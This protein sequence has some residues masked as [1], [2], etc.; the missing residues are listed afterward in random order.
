[1]SINLSVD[2]GKTSVL[3]GTSDPYIIVVSNTGP[4]A[5]TGA[6]VSD[7]LPAGATAATWTSTISGGASVTG[8]ASGSGALATTVNLPASAS[9]TFTFA[10]TINPSATGSFVNAATVTPP[11]GIPF[12]TAD[13]DTLTPTADLSVTITDGR[14]TVVPGASDTYTIV[15]SNAGPSTAVAGTVT[16]LFPAAFT[17]VSWTAVASAGSSVAAATGIGNI[18]TAV[19]L[20]PF[21]TATYTVV[22]L[23][24]PSAAGS[25]PTPRTLSHSVSRHHSS[26]F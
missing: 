7:A 17:S 23:V 6:F 20:L 21:G 2:D 3:P 10:T 25:R 4:S 19:T 1:M 15:V 18:N 26:R 11:G 22:A 8:P 9:V 16:D 5:V 14:T 12:V 13:T 24:S